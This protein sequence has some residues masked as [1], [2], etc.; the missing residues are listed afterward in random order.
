MPISSESVTPSAASTSDGPSPAGHRQEIETFSAE[1][2]EVIRVVQRRTGGSSRTVLAAAPLESDGPLPAG[3][4]DAAFLR[5]S[6]RPNWTLG[7][8]SVGFADLFCGCGSLALGVFEAA[9]ALHM[10]GELRIAGDVDVNAL[11][12]LRASL[13]VNARVAARLNLTR[14]IKADPAAA[15]SAAERQ[16][17]VRVGPAL[18]IVVAGPPCQGHS[19]LNNH[20]RH[21][22]VRNHLYLRV[23]R[24]AALTEPDYVMIENV[25]SIERDKRR[26]VERSTEGL[27]ALGYSVDEDLVDLNVLGAPQLRCRHVLVASAPQ[28]RPIAVK[29]VVTAHAVDHPS[30][31]TLGWALDDLEV[32]GRVPFDRASV[33]SP[34]NA[35]RIAWLHEHGADDLP[36]RL[37]PP[38]HHGSHSYKSMYG[39]LRWDRPAQT[40]TSGYG[41][42]GQGRYVHPRERRTLTPHEAARLQMI[43]DF[44]DFSPARSRSAWAQMIG[45]AAPWKL[46]YAFALEMLR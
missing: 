45:N 4:A 23:V 13:G 3:Q 31:R 18:R 37:R 32:P 17:I 29:D 12:V 42:M 22:D 40:I 1:A 44:F 33:P 26:S 24:F 19:A 35:R 9:R 5:R 30:S 16:L 38:C 41:S 25:A 46:A 20:S 14:H 36:N 7:S 27:L 39:R 6:E 10:R 11:R 15:T 21:D 2:G 43:P 8:P 28:L 34:E